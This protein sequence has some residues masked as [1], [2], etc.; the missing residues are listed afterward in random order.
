[1]RAELIQIEQTE[2]YLM[3]KLSSTDRSKFEARMQ[4]DPNM[5]LDVDFQRYLMDGIASLALKG[6]AVKGFQLYKLRRLFWK[7]GFFAL[8]GGT[9]VF[10]IIWWSNGNTTSLSQ[11]A[12]P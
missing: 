9:V 10:S 11:G 6:A 7:I 3:G 12:T 2:Q 8:I 4:Q 5:K 1:M